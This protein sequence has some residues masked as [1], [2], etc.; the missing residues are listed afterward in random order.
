MVKC[1]RGRNARRSLLGHD[2]D[3]GWGWCI[4]VVTKKIQ[5]RYLKLKS[6]LLHQLNCNVNDDRSP[7]KKSNKK[8]RLNFLYFMNKGRVDLL[9]TIS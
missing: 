7:R 6:N 5:K 2:D 1:E 3:D 4:V 9:K 8:R